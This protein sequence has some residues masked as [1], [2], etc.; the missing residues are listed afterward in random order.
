VKST[1]GLI[2]LDR[3]GVLNALVVHPIQGTVDS[4][5]HPRE[6]RL[7]PGV[8]RALARLHKMGYRLVIVSNQPSAAKGKTTRSNLEKIHRRIVEQA[9]SAGA[10]I[11][12]SYLCFHRQE[13]HCRCRKPK[14]GLLQQAFR[15]FPESTRRASW[16]VG[17]GLTDIQA[18]QKMGLRT[19]FLAV[20]KCDTCQSLLRQRLRPTLWAKDLSDFVRK[21]VLFQR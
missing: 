7:L 5:M 21:I 17:D 12:R 15:D 19:A 9:E 1:R 14:P 16:M 8:P 6:V 11:L 13:D 3:D 4:A 10:K 20:H 18:G 2:F